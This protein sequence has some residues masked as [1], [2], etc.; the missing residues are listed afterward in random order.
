MSFYKRKHCQGTRCLSR[1]P[2]P[3]NSLCAS[4]IWD[5]ALCWPGGALARNWPYW[6]TIRLKSGENIILGEATQVCETMPWQGSQQDSRLLKFQ[7]GAPCC[8]WSKRLYSAWRPYTQSFALSVWG[9]F[10]CFMDKQPQVDETVWWRKTALLIRVTPHLSSD[11]ILFTTSAGLSSQGQ[12]DV[13]QISVKS[14]VNSYVYL[15]G[16]LPPEKSIWINAYACRAISHPQ[17]LLT[18][19]N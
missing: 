2:P 19:W 12:I 16:L 8:F 17:C 9:F 6:I 1:S 5:A 15:G 7:N 13:W 4:A 10:A 3:P 14:N 18:T 11:I